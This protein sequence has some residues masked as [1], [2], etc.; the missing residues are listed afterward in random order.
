MC[1]SGD[2]LLLDVYVTA[3]GA[4][5]TVGHTGIDTS[6]GRTR[7]G[8]LC[9][10]RLVNVGGT[11]STGVVMLVGIAS[12]VVGYRVSKEL[13]AVT[14][15][16]G[17]FTRGNVAAKAYAAVTVGLHF[18]RY[19]APIGRSNLRTVLDVTVNCVA[20]AENNLYALRVRRSVP[21]V[22][23]YVVTRLG[24]NGCVADCGCTAVVA[25]RVQRV[26]SVGVQFAAVENEVACKRQVSIVLYEHLDTAAG[27]TG[28]CTVLDGDVAVLF[29]VERLR[30]VFDA[31]NRAACYGIRVTLK[32]EVDVSILRN[33]DTS[34]L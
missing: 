3:N 1:E 21:N 20:R 25:Q 18:E 19:L 2:N 11:A 31:T 28:D 13:D 23:R 16:V 7:D 5:D 30:L 9:A 15:Y 34:T 6:C 8:Y 4:P 29:D 27:N 10:S 17:V 26:G 32:A 33:K 12:P 24:N 22:K 14:G